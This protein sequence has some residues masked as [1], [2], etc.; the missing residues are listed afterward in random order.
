MKKQSLSKESIR[1]KKETN[2]N[3]TTGKYHEDL[4]TGSTAGLKA[5]ERAVNWRLNDTNPQSQHHK[6]SLGKRTEPRD[7][8]DYN[9][10]MQPPCPPSSGKRGERRRD[11]QYSKKRWLKFPKLGHMGNYGFKKLR[12]CLAG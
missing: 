5:E 1:Y 6:N 7:P 8:G 4:G 11:K 10:M 12:K 2:G 3:I 9:K